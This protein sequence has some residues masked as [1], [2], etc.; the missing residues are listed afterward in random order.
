MRNKQPKSSPWHFPFPIAYRVGFAHVNINQL[1]PRSLLVCL[2]ANTYPGEMFRKH[3][4]LQPEVLEQA[5]PYWRSAGMMEGACQPLNGF[6]AKPTLFCLKRLQHCSPSDK[7]H[8][9]HIVLYKT[10][11]TAASAWLVW[12]EVPALRRGFNLCRQEARGWQA[13]TARGHL[14]VCKI[15][16]LVKNESR[17]WVFKG[18]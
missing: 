17:G 12:R 9:L 15:E 8:L 16:S 11:V 3:L 5:L 2:L 7:T 18:R 13:E 1:L 4:L 10:L 6:T 14:S